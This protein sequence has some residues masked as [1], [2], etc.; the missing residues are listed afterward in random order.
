MAEADGAL[1][2]LLSS[3]LCFFGSK[4]KKALI[5]TLTLLKILHKK[6]LP[7][8]IKVGNPKILWAGFV[9]KNYPGF[10]GSTVNGRDLLPSLLKRIDILKIP[11]AGLARTTRPR[12]L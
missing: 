6:D 9:Q 3:S 8:L 7:N 12:F 4:H 1:L 11:L 10:S 2:V 5:K